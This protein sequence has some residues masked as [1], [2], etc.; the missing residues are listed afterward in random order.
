MYNV[1]RVFLDGTLK[2][3]TFTDATS[4]KYIEGETYRGILGT[5]SFIVTKVEEGKMKKQYMM[6][7][8]GSVDDFEG[9]VASTDE[10]EVSESGFV[11]AEALVADYIETGKLVEVE[12]DDTGDWVER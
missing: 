8:T 2:G 7:A 6:V 12:T 1:T 3:L 11:S 10:T 4:V 5:S 9:W